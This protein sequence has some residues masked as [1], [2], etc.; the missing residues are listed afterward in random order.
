MRL[1]GNRLSSS[2]ILELR[3]QS[4]S[5]A[6]RIALILEPHAATAATI[7]AALIERENPSDCL[8]TPGILA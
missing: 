6:S 4:V 2:R 7:R 1:T 8:E 3:A 5:R